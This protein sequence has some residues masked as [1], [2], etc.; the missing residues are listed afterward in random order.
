LL[1]YEDLVSDTEVQMRSLARF[2]GI[3]FVPAL[4][5]PTLFG[6][7]IVVGTSSRQDKSVFRER[8]GFWNGI[9]PKEVVLL[10][11]IGGVFFIRGLLRRRITFKNRAIR[12]TGG[13]AEASAFRD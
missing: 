5:Y 2:L 11:L 4:M 13:P 3:A 7:P 12:L 9:T 10:A 8:S 1:Y 6:E